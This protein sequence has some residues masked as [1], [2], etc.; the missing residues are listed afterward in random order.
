MLIR[1]LLDAR[2]RAVTDLTEYL[3]VLG[4]NDKVEFLKAKVAREL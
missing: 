4:K 1:P 3:S 2:E